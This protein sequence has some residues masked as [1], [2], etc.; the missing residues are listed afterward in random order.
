[1][2]SAKSP[3]VELT[4]KNGD[5][6]DEGREDPAE[7]A[8]GRRVRDRAFFRVWAFMSDH[9]MEWKGSHAT[10]SLMWVHRD[11][12]SWSNK[13]CLGAG[14]GSGAVAGKAVVRSLDEEGTGD[15]ELSSIDWTGA[16]ADH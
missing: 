4:F 12:T 7:P 1:M 11:T 14:K 13:S 6:G 2:T 5:R 10:H 8:S 9:W 16:R 3:E 15:S